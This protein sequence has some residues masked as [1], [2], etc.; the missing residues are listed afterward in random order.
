MQPPPQPYEFLGE[1]NGPKW[2]GLF[3]PALRKAGFPSVQP[4]LPF[5]HSGLWKLVLRNVSYGLGELYRALSLSAQVRQLQR[6]I[7]EVTTNDVLR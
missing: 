2:R 5:V 6:F 1:E 3:V 7:P 4:F